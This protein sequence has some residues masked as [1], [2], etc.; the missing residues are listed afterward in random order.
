MEVLMNS[1]R[2]ENSRLEP[3]VSLAI[4]LNQGGPSESVEA[5]TP[6]KQRCSHECSFSLEEYVS[7]LEAEIGE[8]FIPAETRKPVLEK[9]LAA[10]PGHYSLEDCERAIDLANALI[11][12]ALIAESTHGAC[13]EAERELESECPGFSKSLYGRLIGWFGYVNR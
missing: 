6:T 13:E 4:S 2:E 1:A 11:F 5:K 9:L 12:S 10:E 8:Y 7:G 3:L